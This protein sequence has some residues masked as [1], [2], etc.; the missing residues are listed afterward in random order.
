[1][2]ILEEHGLRGT[3]FVETFAGAVVGEAPLR[4]AYAE[5]AA[6]GHDVQLHLHPVYRYYALVGRGGS[7][8]TKCPPRSTTSA[9]I[10]WKPRSS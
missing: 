3:F 7:R 9:R 2:D 5:I 4:E 6:R 10:R 1:M 8:W